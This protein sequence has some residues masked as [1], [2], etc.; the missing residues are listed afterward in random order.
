MCHLQLVVYGHQVLL[1]QQAQ[2]PL[3]AQLQLLTALTPSLLL[4]MLPPQLQLLSGVQPLLQLLHS[5]L[6]C[7]PPFAA[8]GG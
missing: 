7:V 5:R 4:L 8:A 1:Q 2:Q 6:P 3:L